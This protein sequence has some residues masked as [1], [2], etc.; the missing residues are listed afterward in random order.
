MEKKFLLWG[1]ILGGLAVIFGAFGAHTLKNLIDG[2]LLNSFETGVRYQFYHALLLLV[3]AQQKKIRSLLLLRLIVVG[4]F[5]FSF[6]IYILALRNLIG[7]ESIKYL[8]PITP[9]GGT[10]L[11]VSWVIVV[12]RVLKIRSDN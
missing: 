2:D 7:I 3:L 5:L 9:L 1:G 10:L 12:T 8:G 6:S 4:I 11:I